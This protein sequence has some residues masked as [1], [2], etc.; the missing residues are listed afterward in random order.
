MNAEEDERIFLV[1]EKVLASLQ[2][3]TKLTS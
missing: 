2:S 1:L 3:F